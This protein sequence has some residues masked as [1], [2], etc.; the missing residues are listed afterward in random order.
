MKSEP[1]PD[2]RRPKKEPSEMMETCQSWRCATKSLLADL[3]KW[4]HRAC[5]SWPMLLLES[6]QTRSHDRAKTHLIVMI[7][8]PVKRPMRIQSCQNSGL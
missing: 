7:P 3:S 6:V 5:T 4:F 1:M 2:D 8:T